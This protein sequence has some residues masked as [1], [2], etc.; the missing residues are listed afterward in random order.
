M[1][2]LTIWPSICFKSE[3]KLYGTCMGHCVPSPMLSP[4]LSATSFYCAV[5]LMCVWHKPFC[6]QHQPVNANSKLHLISLENIAASRKSALCRV[7][8]TQVQTCLWTLSCFIINRQTFEDIW[9]TSCLR[10][11][12]QLLSQQDCNKCVCDIHS[13]L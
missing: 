12:C 8:S 4:S 2:D 3:A 5:V 7:P 6:C 13:L 11:C 9:P 10:L 1:L